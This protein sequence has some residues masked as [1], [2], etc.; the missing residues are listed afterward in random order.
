MLHDGLP[1]HST[2]KNVY[3]LQCTAD[4]QVTKHSALVTVRAAKN[5]STALRCRV[6]GKKGSEPEKVLYALADKEELLQLYAVESC[7]LAT[8]ECVQLCEGGV[9]HP[10]KKRWD[11]VSLLPHGLLVEVMGQGHSSRP[12]TKPNSTED[13]LAERQGKDYAYARAAVAQG[14]SVLWLWVNELDPSPRSR[15]A[16]WAAQFRETLMYV[17]A[18]GAPQHFSK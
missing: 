14:W 15:A 5:S 4:G 16:T 12:V 6:C 11:L 13:S 8:K 9:V 17:C 7:C 18:G 3:K 1:S 2:H 10:N